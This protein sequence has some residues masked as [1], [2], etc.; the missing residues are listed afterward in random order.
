MK[1]GKGLDAHRTNFSF[2]IALLTPQQCPQPSLP[3]SPPAGVPP[4]TLPIRQVDTHSP[5]LQRPQDT[6]VQ[7]RSWRFRSRD[8]L[9][10][11]TQ[12]PVFMVSSPAIL[13]VNRC[14][15]AGHVSAVHRRS[16]PDELWDT[17]MEAGSSFLAHRGTAPARRPTAGRTAAAPGD[18]L[19]P[20]RSSASPLWGLGGYGGK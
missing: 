5:R 10:V 13:A 1:A 8:H 20:L 9:R 12:L 3:A 4:R 11:K 19:P 16:R 17:K 7:I 15:V 14:A 6:L 2:R 18:S